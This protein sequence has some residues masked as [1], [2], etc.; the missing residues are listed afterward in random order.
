MYKIC[1]LKKSI[2]FH[3]QK[4]YSMFNI[5]EPNKKHNGINEKKQK[6]VTS[7]LDGVKKQR[8][9]GTTTEM[10]IGRHVFDP[11]KRCNVEWILE[12]CTGS[13]W[14]ISLTECKQCNLKNKVWR[15]LICRLIFK[16]GSYN[17][18]RRYNRELQEL[19]ET[20]PITNFI[21]RLDD[22]VVWP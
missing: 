14:A 17:R 5:D 16:T 20:G 21:T 13:N 6:L 1:Q 2:I 11:K 4:K 10:S 9:N 12:R 18:R 3:V 7:N 8:K 19:T 15:N 22:P